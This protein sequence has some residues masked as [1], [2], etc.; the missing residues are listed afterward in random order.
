[1][2][3]AMVYM[4]RGEPREVGPFTSR[5]AAEWAAER[6]RARCHPAWVREV[7]S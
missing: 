4:V 1:M 5:E 7:R 2:T 3:Y 6:R